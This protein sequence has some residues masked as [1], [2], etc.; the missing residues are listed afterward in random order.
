M[1]LS[2]AVYLS[3]LGKKGFEEL[4]RQN[5]FKAHYAAEQLTK[6]SGVERL[7][8]DASFF[9]E[10]ALS[11][12]VDPKL[13]NEKLLERGFLGGFPLS[14]WDSSFKNGWL[15]AVTE[16]RSKEEI[17]RFAETVEAVLQEVGR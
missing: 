2:A 13:V 6:I 9:N 4:G 8:K 15:I 16:A 3:A 1:A 17:D 7:F 14:D 11:L 10:F 12:P 5:I